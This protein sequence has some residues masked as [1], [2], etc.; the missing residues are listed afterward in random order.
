MKDNLED[1]FNKH[2]NDD[3]HSSE[4]AHWNTPGDDVWE[5][6]SLQ[7]QKPKKNRK[8]LYLWLAIGALFI[9]LSVLSQ[10]IIKLESK[11]QDIN[12]TAIE[13]NMEHGISEELHENIQN[14]NVI[15]NQIKEKSIPTI[16]NQNIQNQKGIRH[17]KNKHLKAQNVVFSQKS[18]SNVNYLIKK[19]SKT[20]NS[21]AKSQKRIDLHIKKLPQNNINI[22]E[23]EDVDLKTNF[24]EPIDNPLPQ[25]KLGLWEIEA[26]Y[27]PTRLRSPMTGEN[28]SKDDIYNTYNFGIGIGYE[29]LPN[30]SITSGLSY[31]K[32]ISGYHGNGKV[33]YDKSTEYLNDNGKMENKIPV[34][35][36]SPFGEIQTMNTITHPLGAQI[37]GKMDVEM[38]AFQ[39]IQYFSVP[40]GLKYH[41]NFCA[42]FGAVFSAGVAMNQPI[43][44]IVESKMSLKNI[45][46]E[47]KNSRILGFKEVQSLLWTYEL[48]LGLQYNVYEN[49][50]IFT[51]A[52]YFKNINPI[53]SH[54]S[55]DT[56]LQGVDLKIGLGLLF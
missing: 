35:V 4:D 11:V 34:I 31:R 13:N 27:G 52:S 47:M 26:F 55:I 18:E 12:T 46:M 29:I 15:E 44:H 37:E 20:E 42:D 1:F 14:K 49:L 53:Y 32:V 2:L 16:Q 17:I 21:I 38:D 43:N 8:Y 19:P 25:V 10:Y 51:K 56:G 7:F 5:K 45:D 39:T 33:D 36:P 6:A 28:A 50:S 41:W 24:Y 3:D 48:G 30:L 23:I 9:G 22:I 40:V 54:D